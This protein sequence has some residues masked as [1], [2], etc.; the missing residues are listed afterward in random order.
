MVK[1]IK[2][3]PLRLY[4]EVASL[5]FAAGITYSAITANKAAI[6][7]NTMMIRTMNVKVSS[8]DAVLA[9][10]VTEHKYIIKQ[11]DGLVDKL[12]PII[13]IAIRGNEHMADDGRSGPHSDR[14]H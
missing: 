3:L 7:G 11:L 1:L 4:I 10:N 2:E 12:D 13:E 6:E 8:H 9:Q 5:I 14:E